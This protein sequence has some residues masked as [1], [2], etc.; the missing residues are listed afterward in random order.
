MKSG[1][2]RGCA[3]FDEEVLVGDGRRITVSRQAVPAPPR[4][5]TKAPLAG[6]LRDVIY[7]FD[8][9]GPNGGFHWRLVLECGHGV[10]RPSRRAKDAKDVSAIAQT[11]FRPLSEK[12]A[13]KRV[14]CH[15]CGSGAVR[16]DPWLLIKACGGVV[17]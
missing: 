8:R 17:P 10:T 13:P 15:H 2:K 9:E 16:R 3:F 4:L 11:M 6:P 7:I 12:L 5:A 14:Q 1:G